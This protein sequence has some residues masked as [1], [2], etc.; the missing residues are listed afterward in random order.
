MTH[1]TMDYSELPED[2]KIDKA[3]KDIEEYMGE[4]AWSKTMELVQD[5]QNSCQALDFYLSMMGVKGYPV[6]AFMKRYRATDYQAWYDNL[7]EA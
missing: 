7:P 2:Q 3:I 6:H 5:P 1:Y 4:K